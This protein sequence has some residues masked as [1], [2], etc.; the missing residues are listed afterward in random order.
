MLP[1]KCFSDCSTKRG[2][3]TEKD[4]VLAQ[5]QSD[6]NKS[7]ANPSLPGEL[8]GNKARRTSER[9]RDILSHSTEISYVGKTWF[10][11]LWDGY[12]FPLKSKKQMPKIPGGKRITYFRKAP[13]SLDHEMSKDCFFT[14]P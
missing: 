5:I 10:P 9:A 6:Q 2:E 7:R 13:S 12:I 1:F 3:R 11:V 8:C 4:N 14:K